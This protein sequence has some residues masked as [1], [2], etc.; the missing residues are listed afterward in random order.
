M[1]S[2][3]RHETDLVGGWT[4][5]G[6]RVEADAICKRI[7]GLIAERL[8]KIAV[9][10]SGWSILHLDPADGRYWELTYPESHLQGGGPPRLTHLPLEDAKLRYGEIIPVGGKQ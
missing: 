4:V 9:G 1:N 6:D 5:V 2:L 10:A 7:E 8:R 3:E